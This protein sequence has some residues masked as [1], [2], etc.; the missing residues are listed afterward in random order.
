[1]LPRAPYRWPRHLRSPRS[2]RTDPC[3][4]AAPRWPIAE[5]RT[6]MTERQPARRRW[7]LHRIRLAAWGSV[8][9]AFVGL[10][11]VLGVAPKPAAAKAASAETPQPRSRHA[12]THPA[13]SKPVVHRTV[14]VKPHHTAPVT[15]V[16]PAPAEDGGGSSTILSGGSSSSTTMPNGGGDSTDGGGST[17][18]GDS[19]GGGSTGGGSTGGGDSTGGGGGSTPDPKPA[20]NPTPDPPAPPAPTSPPPPPPPPPPPTT[21]GS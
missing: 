1:M 5:R 4:R 16:E 10:V 7:S 20:S 14:K 15:V 11:G 17:T 21:G 3:G 6:T 18:G 2:R 9:T 13:K 8:A 19:S 12:V